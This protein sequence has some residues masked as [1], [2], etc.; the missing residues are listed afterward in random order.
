[1]QKRYPGCFYFETSLEPEVLSCSI[2]KLTLQPL[3]ENSIIHG[4][5][6]FTSDRAGLITITGYQED[7][8]ICLRIADNGS[9][10][11]E[12]TVGRLNSQI[13][14]EERSSFGIHIK[15][16]LKLYFAV[17][18][19]ILVTSRISEGTV[20]TIR[21]SQQPEPPPLE[22]IYHMTYQFLIVDDEYFVRQRIRLCIPW[23]EYGFECAGEAANVDQA[24]RFLE[25]TPVDLVILDISMPGANGLELLPHDERTEQPD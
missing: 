2:P 23:K 22:R 16:R 19:I 15:K 25:A 21:I 18:D 20:I 10:M 9:G 7:S 17:A 13:F 11:D 1:M 14:S 12:E 8:L 4:L 6:L 24:L 5:Q 3:V